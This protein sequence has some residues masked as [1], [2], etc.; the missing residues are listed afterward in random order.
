MP[1]LNLAQKLR[2]ELD[3][4]G[5]YPDLVARVIDVALADEPV[6]SYLVHPETTFDEAEVFRHL[7][8]LVLTP[9]RLVFA[10]VDDGPGPDGRPSALATTES[11]PLHQVRS[12]ALTHGVSDPARTRSM[13]TQELTVAV[14]WGTADSV[15]LKP[16][17]CDDPECEAD[18]G[19]IGTITPEGL[20]VR[21]SAQAE[22]ADA[23]TGAL[24]FARALSAATAGSAGRA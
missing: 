10:H 20:E 22:G 8:T 9:T 18:H 6:V 24:D 13:R 1:D 3:L 12:V 23:L 2:A 14:S 16:D 4:A 11:V 5:Y 15:D 21:V 19:Y 7:T 17:H